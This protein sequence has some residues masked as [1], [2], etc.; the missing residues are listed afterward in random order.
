MGR[1]KRHLDVDGI[2]L[3]ENA[4]R[5]LSELFSQVIISVRT[6]ETLIPGAL[7]VPDV[8]EDSGPLGAVI[9]TMETA[10]Y[11]TVFVMACDIP[12]PP[13]DFIGELM[14]RA[15][16]YDVVVP[17]DEEGRYETLFALYRR[18]I[19][20]ELYS[21]LETGEKRIRMLYPQVRTLELTIPQDVT[22]RNLNT[23][24]DFR[25]FL[26]GPEGP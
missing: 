26:S 14:S 7:H 25:K 10:D 9:S 18:S 24:E 15:G 12:Y 23:P 8:F 17:V 19:L 20:P 13:V 4:Y 22:L 11:E 16:G 3:V 5:I 1:D 6:P 21:L 2:S